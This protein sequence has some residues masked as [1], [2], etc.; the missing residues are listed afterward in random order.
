[1]K[2]RPLVRECGEM[3]LRNKENIEGV[4]GSKEGGQ[5]VYVLYDGSMPVYIGRGN[6]RR[7]IRGAHHSKSRG[8]YWDHFSWYALSD[9][10]LI[11]DLEALL[12]RT[13]PWYVRGLNRQSGKFC[14]HLASETQPN[15]KDTKPIRRGSPRRK[16]SS[17]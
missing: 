5:G 13:L 16:K 17:N 11:H 7:R 1:M 8:D 6:I 3:W 10:S 14:N 2:Q 9:P 12:L 15:E 4:L